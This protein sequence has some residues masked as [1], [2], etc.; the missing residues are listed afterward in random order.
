[1]VDWRVDFSM[2]DD[3]QSEVLQRTLATLVM[4]QKFMEAQEER[5][6]ALTDTVYE[7]APEYEIIETMTD[8]TEERMELLGKYMNHNNDY[9]Q[10]G[11]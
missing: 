8:S 10:E 9:L 2:D 6:S 11:E 4:M 3:P 5:I 1:M 7:L